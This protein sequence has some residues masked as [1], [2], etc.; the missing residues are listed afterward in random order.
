MAPV[1]ISKFLATVFIFYYTTN[2]VHCNKEI[3]SNHT[4]SYKRLEKK[5]VLCYNI[6]K[7]QNDS[8]DHFNGY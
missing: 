4:K 2:F 3:I 6:L 1:K 7:I 5:R 8:E